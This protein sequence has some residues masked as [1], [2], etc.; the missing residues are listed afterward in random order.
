VAIAKISG[1]ERFIS[2]MAHSYDWE[3][4]PGCH[5]GAWRGLLAAGF[6]LSPSGLLRLLHSM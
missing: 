1:A 4:A 6:D 2:K 3:V 5:L